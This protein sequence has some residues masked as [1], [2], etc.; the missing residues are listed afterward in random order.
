MFAS[1]TTERVPKSIIHALFAEYPRIR[2]VVGYDANWIW[3][4]AS[5]L[6]DV[7]IEYGLKIMRFPKPASAIAAAAA[8]AVATAV[9]PSDSKKE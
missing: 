8:A 7:V 9:K 1:R 5:K 2:Y 4:P 6:P 3:I